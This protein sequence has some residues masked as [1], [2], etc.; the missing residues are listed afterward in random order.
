MKEMNLKNK[1]PKFDLW[2]VLVITFMASLVMSLTTG[3]VVYRNKNLQECN[4]ANNNAYVSEFLRTYNQI[5]NEYYGE[6]DELELIRSAINGMTNFLNDPYTTYLNPDGS[7][8][9][10]DSL[11]GTYEGIG[12]EVT[13]NEDGQIL[14]ARVFE[15]SPAAEAGVLAGDVITMINKVSLEGK[16]PTEAVDI[17]RSATDKKVEL[18]ISR[19]GQS[20]TFNM[21]KTTLFLPTVNAEI[22]ENNNKKIG[23]I[24]ILRFTETIGEQFKKDLVRLESGNIDSLIID[25]RGN[26]GGYLKGA[27]DIASI[28]LKKN[29]VIYSMKSKLDTTQERVATNEYRDYKVYVLINRGSASASEILAAALKYS[30]SDT[31]LIGE[32]SY[33]KGLIQQTSPLSSGSMLKFTTAEWLTPKGYSVEGKGLIPCISVNLSEEYDGSYPTDNQLQRAIE[34]ISR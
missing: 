21:T 29:A 9:L 26:Q 17:I 27:T 30:Y 3:F 8:S 11:K 20:M 25:L 31:K 14:I 28:F 23:Y 18:V 6:V 7:Q 5:V 12:I 24:S 34:E 10:I 2:E 13:E 1:K 32:V 16:I 15:N 4:L 22:F 19:N 33:G